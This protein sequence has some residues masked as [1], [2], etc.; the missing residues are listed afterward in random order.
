MSTREKQ[1]KEKKETTIFKKK[2]C[3]VILLGNYNVI[4]M[5]LQVR[6]LEERF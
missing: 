4:V 3:L 6:M 2:G 5:M 1:E